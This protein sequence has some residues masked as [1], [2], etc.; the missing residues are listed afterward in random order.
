MIAILLL[1]IAHMSDPMEPMSYGSVNIAETYTK[2]VI[3]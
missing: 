3:T 2:T 1:S